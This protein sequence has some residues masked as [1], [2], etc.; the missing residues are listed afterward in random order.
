[1]LVHIPYALNHPL[2][3]HAQ[4]LGLDASI[5]VHPLFLCM[6]SEVSGVCTGSSEPSLLRSVTST[7]TSCA[8]PFFLFASLCKE[9]SF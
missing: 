1:M 6:R 9:S 4:L 5:L 7:K 2:N 3:M 8:G